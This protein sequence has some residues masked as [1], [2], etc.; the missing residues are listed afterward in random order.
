M[1]LVCC[2]TS[3]H[4]VECQETVWFVTE[5]RNFTRRSEP[6]SSL[7]RNFKFGVARQMKRATLCPSRQYRTS[8]QRPRLRR[9]SRG[10]RR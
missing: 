2:N 1:L 4:D 10:C 3:T 6:G 9:Y 8:I 7:Y 5:D